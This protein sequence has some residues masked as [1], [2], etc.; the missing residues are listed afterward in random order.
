MVQQID[1]LGCLRCFKLFHMK[2]ISFNNCK[3][4]IAKPWEDGICMKD[5][6]FCGLKLGWLYLCI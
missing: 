1:Q 5:N 4:H 2:A 3:E 6:E